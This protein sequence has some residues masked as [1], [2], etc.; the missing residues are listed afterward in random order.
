VGDRGIDQYD[1]TPRILVE[2]GEHRPHERRLVHDRPLPHRP[3]QPDLL[4]HAA[5]AARE[6]RH[7]TGP[8]PPVLAPERLLDPLQ[9]V[10]EG[11]PCSVIG[12]LTV[13]R[14]ADAG[15]E[16]AYP[17]HQAA[18]LGGVQRDLGVQRDHRQAATVQ[19]DDA[20]NVLCCD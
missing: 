7:R 6:H 16:A 15:Q 1:A 17:A 10:P 11:H 12:G 18:A 2:Y 5:S 20:A 4:E 14:L 13:G 19:P 9:V 8:R 3:G